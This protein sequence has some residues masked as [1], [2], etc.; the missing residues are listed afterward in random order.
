[1]AELR[2]S[3][4]EEVL[5]RGELWHARELTQPRAESLGQTFLAL[6]VGEA[7]GPDRPGLASRRVGGLSSTDGIRAR[8]R[9]L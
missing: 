1:M 6:R 3:L 5:E 7:S 4:R 9:R 8:A 2:G